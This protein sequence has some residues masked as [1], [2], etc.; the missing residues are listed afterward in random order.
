M[1]QNG[2]V[3]EAPH[4][5]ERTEA[6]LTPPR[7]LEAEDSLLG[8]ILLD[9]QS[10]ARVLDLARPDD[11][12]RE[13]NGAVYGAA[14]RLFR[15]GEPIDTVTVAGELTKAGLLDRV[16]G[17]AHLALLQEN[18][19][20]AA[21]IETYARRIRECSI[22]RQLIAAGTT[23]TKR[24]YDRRLSAE[25]AVGASAQ[26]ILGIG[27]VDA[28]YKY[29]IAEVV[30]EVLEWLEVVRTVGG[31]A[32]MKC[33]LADLDELTGGWKTSELVI[34]GAR[35]GTGKTSLAVLAAITAARNGTPVLFFT[36]EMD[37]V[38]LILRAAC[39]VAGVDSEA[40]KRNL[41]GDDA[42]KRLQGELDAMTRLPITVIDCPSLDEYALIAQA[43]RAQMQEQVGLVVVDYLQL[44]NG[45]KRDNRVQEV[46]RITRSLKQIARDLRCPVLALAQ[47]NREVE[48]RA[49]KKPQLSDLRET[50]EIEAT[51]D[52]VILIH[53]TDAVVKLLVAKNRNGR[54]GEVAVGFRAQYTRFENL[55][56]RRPEMGSE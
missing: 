18:C 13:N 5:A 55:E 16:G 19:P 12:Y 54:T 26:Q 2:Y 28:N 42:R 52:Q 32:G 20:T 56:R 51:A 47:L 6:G 49:D 44:V 15:Q 45:E 43:R 4:P 50:G 17:R 3:A 8:A 7:D 34:V 11:L 40:V 24:G 39:M 31:I 10:I 22:K 46:S 23:A 38:S 14:L 9:S 1:S 29:P 30:D 41:L 35:P 37:R 53:R 27:Q 36:I 33:G 48:G 25:E 21:N